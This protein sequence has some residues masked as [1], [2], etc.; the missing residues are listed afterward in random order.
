MVPVR[1][2][3]PSGLYGTKP[4]PSS[5]HAASTSSSGRRHHS[6]YSLCTAVTGCTACARRIVPAAA[7][8]MPKCF[9][10]PASMSSLTAPATSS[11]GHVRVDP[12]LVVEV[13]GLD[14]EPLQRAVDDLL[15]HLGAARHPAARLALDGSMSQPNLVAITTWSRNGASASPTSSSLAY[16]P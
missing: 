2:P 13:D 16:G 11:I 3:L 7:S 8:D 4:M 1:K 14:A 9:T 6:E 15:D 12:V 10:L 5:S